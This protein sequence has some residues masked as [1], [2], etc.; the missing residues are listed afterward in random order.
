MQIRR[1]DESEFGRSQVIWNEILENSRTNEVFLLWE[2]IDSWWKVFRN[3]NRELFILGVFD[4]LGGAVGFAPL[5]RQ[6]VTLLGI[7]YG[8][9]L[10][11]CGD[12]EAY[13]DH[14]DF[15]CRKHCEEEFLKVIFRYLQEHTHAWDY[16]DL[17]GLSD[18]SII[19]D[20]L[21]P[22]KP[23]SDGLRWNW[24]EASTCPYLDTGGDFS[25]YL[26]S[27]SAKKRYT[28]L[29]KRRIL[30]NQEEFSVKEG[31]AAHEIER[32]Y[33][34]LVSLHVERAA[35]KAIRSAFSSE[36]AVSFHK[37]LINTLGKKDKVALSLLYK[38][39]TPLAA[40]YCYRHNRKYYF[41]QSGISS[42]GEE[43]SAGVVLLSRMIQK[44]FDEGYREF[45]FL[46]GAEEYKEYWTHTKR[47]NLSL[48]IAKRTPKGKLTR[49]ILGWQKKLAIAGNQVQQL[50]LIVKGRKK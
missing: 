29:K 36:K 19:R 13:S 14:M 11:L 4:N 40:Y 38:K 7:H 1:I 5:Y 17:D 47:K 20:L 46:R 23:D 30:G 6:N 24:R 43:H 35:R 34:I 15:F 21:K 12:P 39:D 16:I 50:L 33:E 27:F 48:E 28:L 2:W 42:E 26:E 9:I 3:G 32:Y 37:K 41:Y 18:T 31:T 25:G 22:E 49:M 45:D 10:K 8:K 44:S